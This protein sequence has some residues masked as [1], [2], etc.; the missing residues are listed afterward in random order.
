MHE[1]VVPEQSVLLVFLSLELAFSVILGVPHAAFVGISVSFGQMGL[2]TITVS[3][4]ADKFVSSGVMDPSFSMFFACLID[5]SFIIAAVEVCDFS[6][7]SS[8]CLFNK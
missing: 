8:H 2:D 3:K 7:F 1:T 5:L 6:S 4:V